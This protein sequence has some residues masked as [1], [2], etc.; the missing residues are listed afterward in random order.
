MAW[1]QSE[2]QKLESFFLRQASSSKFLMWMFTNDAM[3][4][5]Q[6]ISALAGA[7]VHDTVFGHYGALVRKGTG[8]E[9]GKGSCK[10][11]YFLGGQEVAKEVLGAVYMVR[12]GS[13]DIE[14]DIGDGAMRWCFASD[15]VPCAADN[16]NDEPLPPPLPM[17]PLSPPLQPS[18][19]TPLQAAPPSPHAAAIPPLSPTLQPSPPPPVQAAPPSQSSQE[20]VVAGVDR[21]RVERQ[22][23]QA[24]RDPEMRDLIRWLVAHHQPSE[25][26][27]TS[28]AGLARAIDMEPRRLSEYMSG[29]GKHGL[30]SSSDLTSRHSE[31]RRA[32]ERSGAPLK[33][34]SHAILASG[35]A[36]DD[37][38]SST[39]DANVAA[40]F[41]A[42]APTTSRQL[43]LP[44]P[45]APMLVMQ[46]GELEGAK[47]GGFVFITALGVAIGG[48]SRWQI[49]RPGGGPPL[50][51]RVGL[52]GR[53]TISSRGSSAMAGRSFE[54]WVETI[55]ARHDAACHGGPLWVARELGRHSELG[56]RIVGRGQGG[57]STSA[58]LTSAIAA[59]CGAVE[60][61]QHL[62]F[63]G[64]LHPAMHELLDA[65][66]AGAGLVDPAPLPAFGA[67]AGGLAKLKQG[68]SQLHAV[69]E[70]ANVAFLEAMESVVPGDPEGV[71]REL[72]RRPSFR[73]QL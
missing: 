22:A 5:P 26:K 57:P 51:L 13:A 65:A 14:I 72:M 54:W 66:E 23:R 60:R 63:T 8:S 1:A 6:Q 21:A 62:P 44:P 27:G 45:K 47:E 42:A 56:K 46:L 24:Q 39:A 2:K 31:L 70:L 68:G 48:D 12:G 28:Q 71:F 61:L 32:L 41:S 20:E 59:H 33:I 37:S 19:P 43:P 10:G 7:R 58:M 50:R 73:N 11:L 67:R 3:E 36:A 15:V 40:S 38:T 29:K 35:V 34:G 16:G 9:P 55:D 53:R 18:P 25:R 49:G 64:L 30:I 69:G 17:P 4:T 52:R